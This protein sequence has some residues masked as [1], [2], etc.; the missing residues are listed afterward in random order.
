V[1]VAGQEGPAKF[2]QNGKY[3]YIPYHRLFRR[4]EL[5]DIEGYG[6]FEGYATIAIR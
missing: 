2:I 6:Q 1:I 4:T 5:I 3:K